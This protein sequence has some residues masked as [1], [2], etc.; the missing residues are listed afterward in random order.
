MGIFIPRSETR[1]RTGSAMRLILDLGPTRDRYRLAPRR[2][3]ERAR[4]RRAAPRQD[5]RRQR[6][7]TSRISTD[8]VKP[9][10]GS[11]ARASPP[12]GAVVACQKGLRRDRGS[13]GTRSSLYDPRDNRGDRATY[14]ALCSPNRATITS[15]A[16]VH[17][18]QKRNRVF[19]A[20]E[21]RSAGRCSR[22]AEIVTIRRGHSVDVKFVLAGL[23]P[24]MRP[25]LH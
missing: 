18:V 9:P 12:I 25:G 5:Y 10:H 8:A 23:C 14:F 21:G 19:A 13:G 22:N 17:L 7:V 6:S 16:F 4:L 1:H 24:V 11:S 15:L 3:P 2:T 20:Y